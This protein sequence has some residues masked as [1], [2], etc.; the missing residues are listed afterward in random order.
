MSL[1]FNL[2]V[3]FFSAEDALKLHNGPAKNSYMEQS[4]HGLNPILNIPVH[5]GQVEAAEQHASLTGPELERW[6]DGLVAEVWSAVDVCS[7]GAGPGPSGCPV[8]QS[9]RDTP[10]SS[11]SPDPKSRLGPPGSEGRI[12]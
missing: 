8:L 9:C 7:A 1:S 10:W 5:L 11:L 2:C 4:F 6:V 12:R 3:S